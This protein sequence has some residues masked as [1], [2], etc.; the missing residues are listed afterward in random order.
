MWQQSPTDAESFRQLQKEIMEQATAVLK[1]HSW[2]MALDSLGMLLWLASLVLSIRV[3][4][5]A[6]MH[7]RTYAWAGLV[8]NTFLLF[9]CL[10]SGMMQRLVGS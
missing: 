10:C 9:A 6:G 8:V 2:L 5:S 4:F 3:I 1:A 7:R